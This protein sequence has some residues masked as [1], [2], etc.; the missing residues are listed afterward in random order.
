MLLLCYTWWYELVDNFFQRKTGIVE[1]E[2]G[3]KES[4]FVAKSEN[5]DWRVECQFQ[6]HTEY[7]AL[8]LCNVVSRIQSPH[9]TVGFREIRL[10][11][12]KLSSDETLI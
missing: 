6:G 7:Y 4:S 12:I 3:W 10:Q 5:S 1:Q 8:A 9:P 2:V 11:F